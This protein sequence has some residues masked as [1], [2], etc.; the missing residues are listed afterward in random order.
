MTVNNLSTFHD[1]DVRKEIGI[2]V[3]LKREILG[4]SQEKLAYAMGFQNQSSVSKIENGLQSVTA[5]QAVKLAK[6]L[7]IPV[8]ELLDVG[9][10]YA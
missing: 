4:I 5:E 3:A 1:A 7:Q 10:E 8:E 6:V 2:R 9:I